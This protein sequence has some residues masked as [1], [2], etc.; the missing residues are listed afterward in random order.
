MDAGFW[1]SI[2]QHLS[3]DVRIGSILRVPLG[4]RKVRGYVIGLDP[5]REGNLKEIL[6]V[7]GEEPVFDAHLLQALRWAANHYV[8]PMS[9]LLDKSAPPPSPAS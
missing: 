8:G 5:D 4:G 1:Y 7:S 9:V 2:P 3:K 6:G